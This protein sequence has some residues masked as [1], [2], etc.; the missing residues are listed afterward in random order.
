MWFWFPFPS[1]LVM[2]NTFSYTCWHSVCFLWENVYPFLNQIF[3]PLSCMISLHIL[4]INPLFIYRICK[5]FLPF[6]RL[7]FHF[8]DG[9]LC[10]AEV[11]QVFVVPPVYF[12][13]SGLCFWCQIQENHLQYQWEGIYW[14]WLHLVL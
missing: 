3:P 10:H 6:C 11:F 4:A 2:L 9:F 5:Y 13:F 8:A 12:C 1:W 7:P 14:L